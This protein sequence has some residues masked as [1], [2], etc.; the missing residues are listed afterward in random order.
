MPVA[1]LLVVNGLIRVAAA[2]SGQLFA[3][4]LAERMASRVGAGAALV[5]LLGAA[6]FATELVG[7][8][9]AG[10]LADRV[11]Q[12]RVLRWG[13]LFGVASATLAAGA[14][15]GLEA[16][17]AL[18]VALLLARL[19]EGS[20]AAAAVPTTLALLSRGT[21]GD[22]ARRTRIMGLFEVTSLVG[23]IAGYVVLGIAWDALGGRAFLL[24]PPIYGAAWVLLR[25]LSE[26]RA[27]RERSGPP[28]VG[29]TLKSLARVPGSVGFGVAWLAVNAVVG[30]WIQQAP[31]LLS[32][33]ARSPDQRL[34]G[35]FTGSDVGLV[36]GVW[37]LAFLLGIAL[38]VWLAP[39]WPRRR[40]MA[41][42]MVG[43][44]GVTGSLYLVNHGVPWPVLG[45]AAAFVLAEAG[46]S[47]AA[48]AHLADLSAP[49]DA[50]RGMVLGLYALALSAGQ[51]VG[52]ILGAPF[53]ARWQMD[54]VLALTA[55][56]ALVAL[57][58]V[59]QLGA[60]DVSARS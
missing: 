17:S 52:N 40:A 28:P 59:S 49:L 42:A 43:M 9:L 55:A 12:V 38:W 19:A 6:F 39:A 44:L 51:L 31:F 34:V 41:T 1:R 16:L 10:R 50:S 18:G 29:A 37:G 32:L 36:L 14:A 56:L 48:F 45:L 57:L 11:G 46:F 54:G 23:M 25:G 35:G 7:A 30:L 58:G 22:R 8:P 27:G 47:P 3:Y 2:G 5:G 60:D 21:E 53:A 13:P 4:F 24:L 33:P 26:P 15:L 20:S